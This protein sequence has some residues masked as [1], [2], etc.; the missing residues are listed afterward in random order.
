MRVEII[1]SG[2]KGNCAVID[3]TLIIDAGWNCTPQGK[4]VLLTHHHTDHTK[5]LDKMGGL[6]V[7]CTQET[8][9]KLAAKYPYTAFN[10]IEAQTALGVITSYKAFELQDGERRYIVYPWKMQHDAPCVAF[11]ICRLIDGEDEKRIFFGTDFSEFDS[12]VQEDTFISRLAGGRYDALYIECNNTLDGSDFDDVYFADDKS[13]KDEFHR[14]KSFQNHCNV[15]YLRSLFERAGYN[16][17]NRFAEP[18]TLLHKSS[19]YYQQN[20]DRIV[21][22]CKVVNITNPML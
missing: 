2:S 19:F 21:D 22:L 7:Y 11:D 16:E 8:A 6:P 9:D 13:P 10:F 5:H 1:A 17:A 4:Y 18:V 3:E 20:I 14:R 12:T 15:G